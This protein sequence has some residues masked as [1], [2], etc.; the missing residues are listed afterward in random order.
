MNR[1]AVA[2]DF[3]DSSKQVLDKAI[4]L[5]KA[6]NGNLA[7]VHVIEDT[8]MMSIDYGPV[9]GLNN[10]NIEESMLLAEAMLKSSKEQMAKLKSSITGINVETEVL[11]GN[12]KDTIIE[13]A[14]EWNADII[15]VGAHSHTGFFHFLEGETSVKI[16]HNTQIPVL[17]IPELE[18]E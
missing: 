17:V 3:T 18:K 9:E 4:E 14:K 2:I 16:L 6:L 8:G 7:L 13:F 15:V 5:T 11:Q 10:I 12:I 1:V